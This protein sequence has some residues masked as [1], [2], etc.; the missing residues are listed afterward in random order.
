ME[1]DRPSVAFA[2]FLD[3]IM[4][5]DVGG[6]GPEIPVLQMTCS[7]CAETIC[8][9][10]DGDDLRL[11]VNTALAHTCNGKPKKVKA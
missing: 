4:I 9:V 5:E 8:A 3:S 7:E 6:K 11:L 10:E 2:R 1:M